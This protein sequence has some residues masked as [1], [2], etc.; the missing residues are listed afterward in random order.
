ME[1]RTAA[2]TGQRTNYQKGEGSAVEFTKQSN[3]PQMDFHTRVPGQGRVIDKDD[4]RTRGASLFAEIEWGAVIGHRRYT[5][6]PEAGADQARFSY[7]RFRQGTFGGL[8][9]VVNV[10]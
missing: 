1:R 9:A 3:L 2:G 10:D 5:E 7:R 8:V 4:Y 6:R